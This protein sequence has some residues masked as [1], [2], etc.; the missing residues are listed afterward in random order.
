MGELTTEL[1]NIQNP[2][3]GAYLM[4]NFVRGYYDGCSTFVPL[5]LLFIILPVIF[6]ED[7]VEVINGTNKSSGLRYFANKFSSRGVLKN[8][9]I[10]QIHLSSENMK[11]LT[12]QSL[13]I[14]LRVSLISIDYKTAMV[15]PISITEHKSE[16]KPIVQ[17]AKASEKLGY[18]C[19]QVTL[20]EVSKILKVRF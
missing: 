12:L 15:F 2:A 9:I 16:S 14:A 10:S 7:L 8:D 17:L 3:L 6:R 20:H 13:R 18:W 4:W 1:H 5:P 11:E 19:S